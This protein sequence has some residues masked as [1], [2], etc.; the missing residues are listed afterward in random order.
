VKRL[1]TIALAGAILASALT[2]GLASASSPQKLSLRKTGAGMILVDAK[3]FTV[4]A[5]SRDSR[6]SDK[7]VMISG[8][9]QNW[10][11]LTASAKPLAGSG[12]KSSLIGTIT[13]KGAVKQVTYSGHPLY[14]YVGDSS[15][16][17][18][19]YIGVSAAGGRWPALSG[20]GSEI[21]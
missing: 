20:S 10:P 6:N 17:S 19:E 2:A 3:G 13:I 11:P 9:A 8:C 7:C 1:L 21:K 12:V 4:Y 18:T 16:G 5:F 14:S 15:P